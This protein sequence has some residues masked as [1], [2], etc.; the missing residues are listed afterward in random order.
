[1]V[2]AIFGSELCICLGPLRHSPQVAR[3]PG[4]DGS[5]DA[6]TRDV[7]LFDIK[8]VSYD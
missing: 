6:L 4:S 5:Q 8:T 1:M 3:A 7:C 2:F